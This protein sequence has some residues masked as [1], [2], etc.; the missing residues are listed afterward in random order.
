MKRRMKAAAPPMGRFRKK[1]ERPPVGPRSANVLSQ[2]WGRYT[3]RTY[4]H[5]HVTFVVKAPPINGPMTLANPYIAAK[6][7]V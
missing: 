2:R 1:L 3:A 5:R 4:H 6:R 7:P